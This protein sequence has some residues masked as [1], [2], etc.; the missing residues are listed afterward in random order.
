MSIDPRPVGT[1]RRAVEYVLPLRW[2][3]D[4]GLDELSDYL[5]ALATWVDVTV[6]DGSPREVFDRHAERWS[7]IVRHVRPEPLEARNGKVVGV[8]T[9]LRLA[10]HEHVVIADDDVRYAHES[11]EAV[12]DRLGDAHAVHPQNVYD[13][14]PWQARWDFARSLVNRSFWRDLG[15][16]TALRRST[17]LDAG[18]YDGD[19]LFEN[20]ELLRTIE[21]AG[22]KID[23]AS[24][25]LVTRRPPTVRHFA[26]QRVRQAY[27]DLAEPGRL[28]AELT[29]LPLAALG[30][31]RPWVLALG[32]LGVVGLAALGRSRA[33]LAGR[34]PVDVPLW[35]PVWLAER[36]VC[37]WL[38]LGYRVTG[39]VP[40]SGS[41]LARAGS[42]RKELARRVGEHR[43]PVVGR[44]VSAGREP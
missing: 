8:L 31:R 4:G 37:V 23:L 35:A 7:A 26:G 13:E 41:R 9:G 30:L 19:V 44:H 3:D 10:R 16:T 33:R 29:I 12:I 43:A 27:D 32:A 15:G 40:Y 24:D 11:L 28:A 36:G 22:G 34:V 20:L 17:L 39:G 38:A 25:V 14:W 18:G 2:T 21:A 1:P 6:V 5:E 42:S